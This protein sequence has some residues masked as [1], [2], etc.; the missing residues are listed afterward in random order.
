MLLGNNEVFVTIFA[1]C[2]D[3]KCGLVPVSTIME[4]VAPFIENNE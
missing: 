3:E 2:D 4:F 1:T